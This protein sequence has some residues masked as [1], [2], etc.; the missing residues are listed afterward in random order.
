MSCLSSTSNNGG[1][2]SSTTTTTSTVPKQ[3]HH[4]EEE[5]E[6]EETEFQERRHA[7]LSRY[8]VGGHQ[9]TKWA[10]S[11]TAY[12]QLVHTSLRNGVSLLEVVDPEGG[13]LAMANAYRQVVQD[14]PDLLLVY[15]S[16]E[17]HQQQHPPLVI[18]TRIGYRTMPTTTATHTDT[19][20]TPSNVAGDLNGGTSNLSETMAL[21]HNQTKNMFF[22]GDVVVEGG[23]PQRGSS[24]I[25]STRG[26]GSEDDTVVHNLSQSY[27][28]QVLESMPPLL[29]LQ[30]DFPD[31]V[32][33][34]YLIHNPEVQLLKLLQ[35]REQQEPQLL[36]LPSLKTRQDYIQQ[37]CA[38]AM[39]GL[40]WGVAQ[41]LLHSYGVVSNGL[42][43]PD[44][45]ALHLAPHTLLNL[46]VS[47]SSSS[48]SSFQHFTTVQLPMNVLERQGQ[49]VA[50]TIQAAGASSTITEIHAI[51]PL[52][53]YPDLGTGNALPLELVDYAVSQNS[54]YPSAAAAASAAASTTATA[55]G[56]PPT[57][58]DP[59]VFTNEWPGPP[60]MYQVAL[61]TALSHFDA[62]ALL[63]VQATGQKLTTEE[64]ETLEGCKLFQS[65]LHDLDAGLAQI[66]SFAAHEQDLYQRIIPLIYDSFEEL[67]DTTGQVLQA[68]FVA[69]GLAVRYQIATHT[70]RQVEV[71]VRQS[72]TNAKKNDNPHEPTEE[73]NSITTI[74]ITNQDKSSSSLHQDIPPSM[75][76][77]EYAL[78]Y[79]LN[80]P[81]VTRYE[82]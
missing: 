16:R 37:H 20:T 56:Q 29:Q 60:S 81:A 10:Q 57:S 53:S 70:R 71:G 51:R 74:T 68:F 52:M 54:L 79:V 46:S 65:M 30:Q 76:L 13:E 4:M 15:R 75:T 9:W 64:R 8:G 67:D 11:P 32:R 24:G 18:T 27:I 55:K 5:E 36:A 80:E 12:Q 19:T 62:D 47:A 26:A 17:K 28:Q 61:Q 35:E 48:S 34:L 2:R 50:Q 59:L 25:R 77:Q 3:N 14:H 33:V 72:Q 66:S 73:Q 82:S 39:Q 63:E 23:R 7:M 41:G 78:R 38:E 22:E 45:H 44:H 6:E 31:H 42:G 40:E 21:H 43:L 1:S 69:Y 58:S 49:S